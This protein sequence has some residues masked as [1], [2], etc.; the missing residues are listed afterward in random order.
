MILLHL[1]DCGE[2]GV[3]QVP[4]PD[5]SSQKMSV[6]NTWLKDAMPMVAGLDLASYS[7]SD[8]Q[9]DL[10]AHYEN[11]SN[12]TTANVGSDEVRKLADGSA[13]LRFGEF[14]FTHSSSAPEPVYALSSSYLYYLDNGRSDQELM[15]G[16]ETR[17]D[18]KV[19]ILKPLPTHVKAWKKVQPGNQKLMDELVH[20]NVEPV[21]DAELRD[22]IRRSNT[23]DY[24]HKVYKAKKSVEFNGTTDWDEEYLKLFKENTD[25][26]IC[27][28]GGVQIGSTRENSPTDPIQRL[29]MYFSVGGSWTD[30]DAV[31][32][33]F[34]Y[35]Q[36]N[37]GMEG[38]PL[39]SQL[40]GHSVRSGTV[41]LI[42]P[43]TAAG[44]RTK[45][46]LI[47]EFFL[48]ATLAAPGHHPLAIDIDSHP[49]RLVIPIPPDPSIN[50]PNLILRPD[51]FLVRLRVS[52]PL[53]VQVNIGGFAPEEVS[54]SPTSFT[55]SQQIVEISATPNSPE[56]KSIEISTADGTV[57]HQLDLHFLTF[58]A[59]PVKFYKLNDSNNNHIT[60]MTDTKLR[61]VLSY[62]NEI[63][64]R[65]TN[66]YLY[67]V[68]ENGLILHDFNFGYDLGNPI[69]EGGMGFT[70]VEDLY[71][72]F[73]FSRQ[74]ENLHVI[75]VWD[76][77]QKGENGITYRPSGWGYP[78]IAMIM[79]DTHPTPGNKADVPAIAQIL[80][81]EIGHWIANVFVLW[82]KDGDQED[83]TGGYEHF[84]HDGCKGGNWS[85]P[86][87][88]MAPTGNENILIT[89]EQAA[90]YHENADKILP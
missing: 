12:L 71:D 88:L 81:H 80:V 33:F 73:A 28:R 67:P 83:C 3:Q 8:Y 34:R 32:T 11:A 57:V 43:L 35:H 13:Q 85:I 55:A 26:P 75:F 77:D 37:F 68:E 5:P 16:A 24:F 69:R 14:V 58:Y 66:V 31:T 90:L 50:I 56:Q 22:L 52:N 47:N 6:S 38:H 21:S 51:H 44:A 17:A 45:D 76:T 54:I 79:I 49:H 23:Q 59:V 74:S 27:V 7:G 30:Q 53:Q 15:G 36:R 39:I 1:F 60:L 86:G 89:L 64:G 61:D 65:Q 19:L 29:S 42:T 48:L 84:A 72:E 25:V 82:R 2:E 63:L 41:D 4:L 9:G 78:D 46:N 87:N 18:E 40:I 62:A 70:G 20:L 10:I